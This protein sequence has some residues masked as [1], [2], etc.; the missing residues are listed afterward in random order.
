M[1][2]GTSK[3]YLMIVLFDPDLVDELK[4]CDDRTNLQSRLV[5]QVRNVTDDK[6]GAI[7]S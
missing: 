6:M 7:D 5:I 2:H 1:W 3:I 4:L